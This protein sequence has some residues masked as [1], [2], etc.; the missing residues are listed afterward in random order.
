MPDAERD[1]PATPIAAAASFALDY[2]ALEELEADETRVWACPLLWTPC[3]PCVFAS[4]FGSA[5]RAAVAER[6][7]ARRVA[8]TSRGVLLTVERAGGMPRETVHLAYDAIAECRLTGAGGVATTTAALCAG[9]CRPVP[10]LEPVATVRLYS[11]SGAEMLAL[12]GLVEPERFIHE[13]LRL[14]ARAAALAALA[15]GGGGVETGGRAGE[16]EANVDGDASGGRARRLP[17]PSVHASLF[18]AQ[19][20]LPGRRSAADGGGAVS[21]ADGETAATELL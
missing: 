5:H 19:L 3:F 10:I 15:R 20:P 13:L 18:A 16:A 21:E 11:A 7:H 6:V 17:K 4:I 9:R 2:A 1:G 14:R 12:R 8:L